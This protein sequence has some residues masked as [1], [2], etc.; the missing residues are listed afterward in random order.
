M[1]LRISPMTRLLAY[2]SLRETRYAH[3]FEL[4]NASRC[5]IH[6]VWSAAGVDQII[7]S[8]AAFARFHKM[9]LPGDVPLG[10][11]VINLT[12]I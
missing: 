9:D 3:C 6:G 12:L 11:C 4:P 7:S 10:M 5:I 1:K 8:L 2:H